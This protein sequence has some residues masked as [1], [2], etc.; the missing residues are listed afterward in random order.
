MPT[1]PDR[2][3]RFKADLLSLSTGEMFRRY[4]MCDECAGL[5]DADQATLR[6]HIAED[7][8]VDAADV[9]IVG[10]AKV[11]FTLVHKRARDPDEADRPP[12]SPFSDA[13]D[14][15]VAIVSD[16]LFDSVW[17][18][19]FEFW[20]GSG[21]ANA[22]TYWPGGTQF[23]DYLFRGWMRPDKLPSEG[24]FKYRNQWFDYFRILTGNRAA[25]DAKITAG[26]Y[27]EAYFLQAYQHIAI[28]QC[29]ATVGPLA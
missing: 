11:G 6:G 7:F 1:D 21:Y 25:G 12:F 29:R 4:V 8:D 20:H 24:A 17:K 22:E 15:D 23:R 26:L 2:I 19:C 13:S 14:V 18:S 5:T 28:E 16:R 10:S 27:R 9:L 3:V